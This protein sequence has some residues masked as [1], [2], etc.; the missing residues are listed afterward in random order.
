VED[1]GKR[2]KARSIVSR[3]KGGQAS[4]HA[5]TEPAG[6]VERGRCDYGDIFEIIV[7]VT[8]DGNESLDSSHPFHPDFLSY[9]W[10]GTAGDELVSDGFRTPLL[11]I[12]HPGQS[13]VVRLRVSASAMVEEAVLVID[14][15]REG[16]CWFA[17]L[18]GDPVKIPYE[19]GGIEEIAVKPEAGAAEGAPEVGA[20]WGERALV[21]AGG[22]YLGWLDHPVV[23]QEC[24]LPKLGTGETNWLLAMMS[25]HDV[26][27]GGRWLSLGCGEG[28]LEL[29]LVE[30]GTAGSIDGV[31]VSEK[32]VEMANAA[33]VERG[34]DSASFRLVD[35]DSDELTG[36]E[37]DVIIASMAI[38]H[39]DSLE[40]AFS[41]IYK[42]LKPG[43]FFFANEYVGPDRFNFPTTQLELAN[44]VIAVLP[45]ELRRDIMAGME[46]GA[47]V[48][49]DRYVWRSPEQWL[50]VDP[51]EAVRSSDIIPVLMDAFD[52][53]RVYEYGGSL[54]HLVLEHIAANFDEDDDR[55]RSLIRLLDVVET[56]LI[57]SGYLNNDFAMLAGEKK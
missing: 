49:K 43:G 20:F 47:T 34:L 42:A 24:V 8:N 21:R 19:I 12:V 51:S 7:R 9:H 23:L 18:G 44:S 41:K 13:Q 6:D 38:H 15:V 25:L 37:Y 14:M 33:A 16:I 32:A 35:L 28:G 10:L 56:T 48:Y 30:G 26:P 5:T 2:K 1:P 17:E 45:R 55:D 57:S 11:G 31:D 4:L 54:L 52:R 36:D 46:R 53:T 22:E 27:R 29:W 40:A 3:L 50:V 39:I